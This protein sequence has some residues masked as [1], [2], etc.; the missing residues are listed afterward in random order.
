MHRGRPHPVADPS[1]NSGQAPAKS[2]CVS[3]FSGLS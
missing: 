1:M 3:M 2:H